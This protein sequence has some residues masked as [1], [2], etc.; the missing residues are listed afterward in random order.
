VITLHELTTRLLAFSATHFIGLRAMHEPQWRFKSAKRNPY[1]GKV[2]KLSRVN[3]CINWRY[4]AAVN[5]QRKREDKPEDFVAVE[6][7]WGNRI[8]HCPL[9]IHLMERPEF[10]L[11]LKRERVERW[12]FDTRTLEPIPESELLPYLP[13][14]AKSRQQLD[15]EVILRDYRLDHIAELT[16]NGETWQI[17]PSWWKLQ[18]IRQAFPAASKSKK[19][20]P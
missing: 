17:D 16:I 18:A 13:K 11:E 14:R 19:V 15:R 2:I 4:A 6:R 3:G 12:Y 20:N 9:I 5:R 7:T 10:Y 8:H 1:L